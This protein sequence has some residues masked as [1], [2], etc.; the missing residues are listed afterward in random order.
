MPLHFE[1]RTR[2]IGLQRVHVFAWSGGTFL[3]ELALEVSVSSGGDTV[4]APTKAAPMTQVNSNAGEVTL[5]V[6]QVGD[7]YLFQFLSEPFISEATST[8]SFAADPDITAEQA[9]AQMHDLAADESP[10][11]E[12]MARKALR[13]RGMALW[14]KLVPADI[15]D[16]FWQLRP[17]IKSFSI[18]AQKDTIPWEMLYPAQ[19]STEEGFLVEQFPVTRRVHNQPR[20]PYVNLDGVRFVVPPHAPS[21]A[22]TEVNAIQ[23]IVGSDR[24]PASVISDL[25]QLLGL[26]EDGHLGLTHFAC[27]NTYDLKKGGSSIAMGGGPFV[28]DLLEPA[29]SRTSLATN[30]PLVFINACRSAGAAPHYTQTIGWAQQFMAAGAGA[31]IGTLWDVRSDS[32]RTFAEA[33]Y[34]AMKS[35]QTLGEAAKQARLTT[36]RHSS[37]PTWLAYTVYGDPAAL[38]R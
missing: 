9:I 8:G 13:A 2:S 38:T 30:R 17:S 32:A 16:H 26:V 25:N 23:R 1:F 15:R 31:F 34:H 22:V 20:I 21:D 19:G 35:G 33:F 37:D 10:Y 14:N 29:V 28:P 18:A 27:H 3:A 12:N 24:G 7:G 36:A 11:S 4:D 5:Q 6:L